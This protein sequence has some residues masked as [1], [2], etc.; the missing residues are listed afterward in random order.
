[1]W[2]ARQELGLNR[3]GVRPV[4]FADVGWAGPRAEWRTPAALLRGAGVGVSFLDGMFRADLSRG[5][6]GG[7]RQTRFDLSVEARF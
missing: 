6:L 7:V 4:V 5:G 2:M 3:A 1:M